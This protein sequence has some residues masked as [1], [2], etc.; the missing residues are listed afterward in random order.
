[1]KKWLLLLTAAVLQLTAA[2]AQNPPYYKGTGTSTNTIPMNNAASLCQQIYEPGDF[3]TLPISGLITKIYFRNS[4]GGASGTYTDFK[5]AFLQNSLT[6]FPNTTFLT[7]ATTALFSPSI[8]IN[9][10]S[11][12]GEWYEIPLTTPFLYDNTQ[13]LI[14]EISYASKT[15]GMSGYTTTASGNKRLSHISSNTPV[16]GNLSSLWGDFGMEVIPATPC[17]NPP[18]AGTATATPFTNIC[19]GT[20]ISLDLTGNSL[21]QGQ[22]Y[23]WES[24]P[25]NT[26]FNPTS[27]GPAGAS[28]YLYTPA[29]TTLWYRAKVVC[30]GN[31][32]VYSDPV[33]VSVNPSFPGG[34]YT[35]NN[36]LPTAGANFNSFADAIA[37]LDCG[38]AG[39]VVFNVTP[40]TPYNETVTIGDIGGTSP[41]NTIRFNG[42]G[43]TVEYANTSTQRQML[44]LSGAK[45]V[46]FDSLT[47]KTLSATYG[48]AALIT[49]GAE[50]DSITHCTFDL[51]QTTTTSSASSS[52]I[53]F[54]ASAT[55]ATSAGNNGSNCYIGY[56]KLTGPDGSGGPYYALPIAGSSDNNVIEGNEIRNFY[57]YGIYVNAASGTKV[58]GNDINRSSKTSVTTFYGIYTTGTSSGTLIAGNR[59]HDPAEA[60]VSSTSTF[61]GIELLGDA[62]QADPCLVYNNAIYNINSAGTVYGIYL[63]TAAE[64]RA[65][66]NTVNIDRVLSGTGTNYGIYAT[67]TNT[68]LQVKNNI[69]NLTAGT[70]GT[71]Y[72]FYYSTAN[73]IEDAQRNNIY[74]NSTQ[75]GTQNY[76]YYTTAY[77][78]QADF[79]L[80]YPTLEAGSPAAD[81]QFSNPAAGDLTPWYSLFGTGENLSALVAEDIAG[82][83][84]PSLPTVG[85]FE[86]PAT[87]LNNAGVIALLSPTGSYC[88]G[89]QEVKVVINNAGTNDITTVQLYWELNGVAQTPVTHNALLVPITSSA[90]QSLDTVSLG[91]GS[92]AP[93]VPATIKVWSYLPN[94]VADGVNSNDTLVAETAPSDFTIHANLDTICTGTSAYFTL[95][96]ATGYV[97]GQLMWQQ[98]ADGINW[99]DILNTDTV[100]YVASGLSSDT[101]YRVRI[102]GDVSNCYTDSAK[103]SVTNPQLLSAPDTGSC[104]PGQ[105]QLYATASPNATVKWY[106]SPTATVPLATGSPFTTPFISTNTSYYVS[107]DIGA[108]QPLPAFAGNGTT[109]TTTTY[110]PFYASYQSLK[111]QYLVKASELQALGFNPGLITAL[112]FDVLAS[113]TTTPLTDFTVK[114][115]T[116]NFS[117]VTTTWETGMTTVFTTAAY[118]ITPLAV[119]QFVLATPF[120]WNGVDDIIVETCYQNT[121]PPTGTSAVRYT[122]GLGFTASHYVYTNTANNCGSPGTGFTTTSRPNIQFTMSSP[123]EG[124]REEVVALIYPVPDVNLG[125]DAS[126]CG[127]ED[128]TV[129]LDA[130]NPGNIYL[131]DDASTGQTR[132]IGSSGSYFVTVSNVFGCSQA[133]SI[134]IVL[135]ESPVVQLGNDTNVCEGTMLPLDAGNPGMDHFW[136]TGNS[137]QVITVDEAGSYNVIVTS[138]D[139]CSA[140]D[141]INVTMNGL[142]PAHDGISTSND[143]MLTYTFMAIDPVNVT[144]YEWNFGDGSPVVTDPQPTHTYA[145][146]DIYTVTLKLYSDCGWVVDTLAAN[147]VG[148][149][150][151]EVSPDLLTLFPNPGRDEVHILNK[152]SLKMEQVTLLN[153]LGQVL[154]RAAADSPAQHVLR[155]PEL[156]SGIYLVHIATDK[157][158]VSRKLQILK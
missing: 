133:D 51:S 41:V 128:Q 15:G 11:T 146:E 106:D 26:P 142:L 9:G 23:E 43:A 108:A 21:G 65:Y 10:N 8:T 12:S 52:G 101:W 134:A 137:G 136:N 93:G 100:G 4:V 47:F 117:D 75:S 151:I 109:T 147:I 123:C 130:G 84:R 38:I 44:T 32:P 120:A 29:T 107:A 61:Y 102:A 91:M 55:S 56:N 13:T 58:L 148:I 88:P 39:P 140:T 66:H 97:A 14:V 144:G 22:T 145:A 138:A 42:N 16:T 48:W 24:S 104:G 131:W 76:G 59:I 83:P 126:L 132:T 46:R 119:N 111:A 79:Q 135:L 34:T 71:K 70:G 156:A 152:G 20:M 82:N 33:Q 1:M 139:G 19:T 28:P 63:S 5:V 2:M 30:S 103:I 125:P 62:T 112:G 122:S 45:Y 80:A 74:V 35:I 87:G 114:L 86:I 127:D 7:G 94:N 36:A 149:G 116:G 78:T 69:V 3:N 18:L 53:C 153:T 90:G 155:L 150:R 81:P 27:L 6:A 64:V 89:Q 124:P 68:G 73:S 85:A 110:S 31:A 57:L 118:A 121:A 113:S 40:G 77:A 99:T 158:I 54:S 143:G 37:A 25:T 105:V 72:G 49:Q 67:G 129:T 17:V 95:A 141:T 154:Y 92:F 98:S 115:K 96:P 50:Y 157:G 60:T